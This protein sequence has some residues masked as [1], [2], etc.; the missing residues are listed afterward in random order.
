[1]A[2]Q[3]RLGR[4]RELSNIIHFYYHSLF[5]LTFPIQKS[6]VPPYATD[7]NVILSYSHYHVCAYRDT[8][9]GGKRSLAV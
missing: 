3:C 4:R 9:W 1:M 7:V 6:F 2:S 5:R 8:D